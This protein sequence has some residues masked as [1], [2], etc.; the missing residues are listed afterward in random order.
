MR[1]I[2]TAGRVDGQGTLPKTSFS[3]TGKAYQLTKGQQGIRTAGLVDGQGT[4]KITSSRLKTRQEIPVYPDKPETKDDTVTDTSSKDT[5]TK[6]N[7]TSASNIQTVPENSKNN[8]SVDKQESSTEKNTQEKIPSEKEEKTSTQD[9]KQESSTENTQDSLAAELVSAQG[10][11]STQELAKGLTT[12][13]RSETRI[14][15]A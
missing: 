7:S 5:D 2:R 6:S 13:R 9:Q 1:G 15:P 12:T 4:P 8:S 3:E 11:D 14:I 10:K